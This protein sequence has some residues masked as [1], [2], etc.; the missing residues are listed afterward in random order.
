MAIMTRLQGYALTALAVLLVLFGAYALGGRTARR[1]TIKQYDYEEA[2]RAAAGA[3]GRHDVDLE[4]RGLDDGA[5]AAELGRDW[6][7]R[8]TDRDPSG[9]ADRRK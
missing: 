4:T 9:K 5:A 3:K 7:R 2:V 6:M 1:A 8:E